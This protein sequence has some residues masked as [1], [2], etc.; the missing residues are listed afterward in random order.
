MSEL[1]NTGSIDSLLNQLITRTETVNLRD[2]EINTYSIPEGFSTTNLEFRENNKRTDTFFLDEQLRPAYDLLEKHKIPKYL[3][4]SIG[5]A[6]VN[7]YV[8]GNKRDPKKTTRMHLGETADEVKIIIEDQGGVLDSAFVSYILEN[9]S[10]QH[11]RKNFYEF[12]RKEK[13]DER[14]GTG[15]MVMHKYADEVQYFKSGDG[16][17]IVELTYKKG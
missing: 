13:P 11:V 5:E 1:L 6:A 8:H 15:T 10:K 2:Y 14:G 9:R 7:A 17:L 4:A 12:S 16:G 3:T